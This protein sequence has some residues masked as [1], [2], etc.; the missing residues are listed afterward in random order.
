MNSHTTDTYKFIDAQNSH[1]SQIGYV[2]Y[3]YNFYETIVPYSIQVLDD[4]CYKNVMM[5]P[6]E[7]DQDKYFEFIE[8]Y[9]T[10]YIVSSTW[11]LKYKFMSNFKECMT[12]THSEQY[13]YT[14]V[15]TDG[16]IH[17]SKHTT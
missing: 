5:L 1:A 7:Y 9:G 10:H 6:E 8:S 16:W 2:L 3:N 17:S 11:G 12:Q 14:Q 13:V 15:E 4:Q